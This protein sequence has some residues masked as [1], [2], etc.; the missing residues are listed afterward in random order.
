MVIVEAPYLSDLLL[1]FLER[2]Q[3]PVISN[4]Y[5][6][7]INK[8]YT[9]NYIGT[10]DAVKRYQ[11]GDRLYTV[12]E[13]TFDWIF[14]NIPNS[15]TVKAIKLLKDKV[16]FRKALADHYPDF[17]FKELTLEELLSMNASKI[18]YPVILKPSIGFYSIGVYAIFNKEDYNDAVYDII[19]NINKWK[20]DF[21]ESVIGSTFILEQYIKGLEFAIDAYYDMDGQPVILNILTRKFL[22][23]GDVG[24]RIYYTSA[25]IIRRYLKQFE[26]FLSRVNEKLKIKDF[27]MHIEL[28]VDGEEIIPIE[29]NPL[30]FTGSCCTDIAYYA[31]GINTVEYYLIQLKPDFDSIIEN[32]TNKIYSIILLDKAGRDISNDSFN[33]QKLYENFE[34]VLDIRKIEDLTMGLFAFL[35][36]ETSVENEQELDTA[37]VSD[38]SE[39]IMI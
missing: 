25:E 17:F 10:D 5:V 3:I 7:S 36:T 8:K 9:L 14:K 13:L 12:S 15:N 23:Q 29:F 22:S 20:N 11:N 19:I 32:K 27:P 33:Y 21:P 18:P 37:L 34:N 4:K 30:R 39:Y 35:F 24:N 2:N 16:A 38:F 1:D 26:V 28:R 6:L 31:Y